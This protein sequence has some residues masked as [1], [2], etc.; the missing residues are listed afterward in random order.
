MG[1]ATI[2]SRAQCFALFQLSEKIAV[3]QQSGEKTRERW[4]VGVM[5]YWLPEWSA[6]V[7]EYWSDGGTKNPILHYPIAPFPRQAVL[8]FSGFGVKTISSVEG[9]PTNGMADKL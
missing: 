4:S 6:G 3:N 8:S 9:G 7:L 5:E 2:L 1:S